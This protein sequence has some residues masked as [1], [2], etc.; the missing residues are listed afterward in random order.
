MKKSSV[1]IVMITFV[2]SVVIVG[3]FGMKMISYN[4][5]I[6]VNAITPTAVTTSA[7]ISGVKL[8]SGREEKSYILVLPYFEG[9]IVHIDY[10][11]NPADATEA[12][13]E[14]T[15]PDPADREVVETQ[16]LNLYAKREGSA[17]IK[18]RAKVGGGAGVDVT[19]YFLAPDEY[20]SLA[21]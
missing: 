15:V 13:V 16:G 10:E 3:I 5:R 21:T 1:I 6:Y 19:L 4:T 18:Y 8:A 2:L 7:N 14:I 9:L 12:T 20:Y 17:R 11:L